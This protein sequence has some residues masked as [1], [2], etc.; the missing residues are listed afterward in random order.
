VKVEYFPTENMLAD[1]FTKPLQGMAFRRMRE[2]IF[3]LPFTN[4]VTGVHR[5]VLNERKNEQKIKDR[6]IIKGPMTQN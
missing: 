2:C 1:I 4:T 6:K 3:N 5:S